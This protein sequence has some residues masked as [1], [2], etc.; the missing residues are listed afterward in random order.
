MSRLRL[1]IFISIAWTIMFLVHAVVYF[2]VATVYDI[3]FSYWFP[4]L[5]LLSIT[6]VL[7]TIGVRKFH[8]KFVDVFYFI[9][10]TWLGTILIF[11]FVTLIF[12]ILRFLGMEENVMML[13]VLLGVGVVLSLYAL[14]IG[15]C[16]VVKRFTIPV[17]GLSKETKVVHLTDVHVGTVHQ[18]AFLNRVVKQTNELEPDVILMTGDLFD[19]SAPIHEEILKPL[20][21]L[22]APTY[23]S[24]GNHEVYEGLDHVRS[25]IAD[26]KM[27][28]LENEFVLEQG[29]QII[30]VHD[31][32]GLPREVTLD[33]ILE[34]LS[35]DR[36]QPTILM[37]HTP[38]EWEAARKHGVDLM[39]SGHT[40]NGQIFPFT[41][42]VRAFF[43]YIKG[44]YQEGEQYLHV[45]PGTGTWGP[46]M[47]LGSHNQ[48]T[49]LT[50]TSKQR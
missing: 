31:R 17:S 30:G 49:L 34:K 39:L 24:T 7:A 41:L 19:G 25:T 27:R 14:F 33:S 40:H 1:G 16:L 15:R 26:L 13:N 3:Q 10:A 47:R 32:Q 37:Y 11:F 8:N 38:V 23:F 20:D 48:I 12:N 29:L 22:N 43:K 46:P 50:L 6:F 5:A 2:T 21:K 4:L 28:L 36:T 45:S 44:L 35:Y 9:A 18:E 42:L